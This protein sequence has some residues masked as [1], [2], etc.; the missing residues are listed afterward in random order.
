MQMIA[1]SPGKAKTKG[2]S[3]EVAKDFI[4]KTK[5]YKKLPKV[6]LKKKDK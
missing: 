1:H 5:D 3:Q 4:S 2:I 6:K